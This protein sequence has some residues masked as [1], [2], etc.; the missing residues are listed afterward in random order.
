MDWTLDWAGAVDKFREMTE[1]T[2]IQRT[3]RSGKVIKLGKGIYYMEKDMEERG[4]CGVMGRE[5]TVRMKKS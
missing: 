4:K 5:K 3:E 1:V 2:E